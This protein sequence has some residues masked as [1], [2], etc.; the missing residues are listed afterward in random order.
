VQFQ[1]FFSTFYLN[2]FH[3]HKRIINNSIW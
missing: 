2:C 1:Q 3:N